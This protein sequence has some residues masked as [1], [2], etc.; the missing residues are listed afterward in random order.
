[1]ALHE[2]KRMDECFYFTNRTIGEKGRIM[3]WCF[4]PLC[5]KCKKEK[6]G[7]PVDAKTGKVKKRADVYVCPSCGYEV[8][9][10]ELEPTLTLNV[11]YTCPYCGKSGEAET[12]YKRKKFQGVDAFVFECRHCGEKIGISKKLKEFKK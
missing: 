4:K 9:V 2:P 5:P 1:M 11:K 10:K 12:Q 8:A 6:L 7:K 3:A